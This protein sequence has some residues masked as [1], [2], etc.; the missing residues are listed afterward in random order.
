[1]AM[2]MDPLLEARELSLAALQSDAE[3]GELR[4]AADVLG[5][6]LFAMAENGD[7]WDRLERLSEAGARRANLGEEERAQLEVIVHIDWA[8]LLNEAGYRPPPPATGEALRLQQGIARALHGG[9]RAE[10]AATRERLASLGMELR[11]LAGDEDVS[12]K[13]LRRA[14][15]K[16]LIVSTKVL[17][18]VGL[19]VGGGAVAVAVAGALPAVAP[20][21]I[22]IAVGLVADAAG[23]GLDRALNAALE[24]GDV[25]DDVPDP[26]TVQALESG[27]R[28]DGREGEAFELVAQWRAYAGDRAPE[29]LLVVTRR[30]FEGVQ[31]GFYDAWEA[32]SLARWFWAVRDTFDEVNAERWRLCEELAEAPGADPV[33]VADRLERFQIGLDRLAGTYLERLLPAV[34]QGNDLDRDNQPE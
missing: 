26:A 6:E 15:R 29:E 17:V 31:S 32:A 34:D 1:M 33:E 9:G 21:V 11:R 27:R 4:Q 25:P 18:T 10:L 14:L 30:Y 28:I 2:P 20:F 5:G 23:K 7:L 12:R 22:Q 16:G 24:G 8:R 13:K 19:I 3:M